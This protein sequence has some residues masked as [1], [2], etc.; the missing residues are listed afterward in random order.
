[1]R[2][3]S[4]PGRPVPGQF[5]TGSPGDVRDASARAG[6]AS[7]TPSAVRGFG[8]QDPGTPGERRVARLA[9]TM[10]ASSLTTPR[11]LLGAVQHADVREYPNPNA[12]ASDYPSGN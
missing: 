2:C 12:V 5:R 3:R 11:Q 8:D 1:M 4:R 10:P 7:D 6:V 9:A